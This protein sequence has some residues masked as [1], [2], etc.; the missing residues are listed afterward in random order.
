[1]NYHA[2]PTEMTPLIDFNGATG[3]FKI[4]GKSF[5]EDVHS[6]Y[7]PALKWLKESYIPNPA[8]S[9]VLT[10]ELHYFNTASAK[11]LLDVFRAMEA[12][13]EKGKNVQIR[14]CYLNFDE[15]LEEAG[16]DYKTMTT[17]PF[18]LVPME[19]M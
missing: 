11:L 5:W 1:M 4:V 18:E 12:L 10:V 3:E 16:E 2:D 7:D 19:E 13:A 9:T 14:W 8:D 15:D 6:V 17:A